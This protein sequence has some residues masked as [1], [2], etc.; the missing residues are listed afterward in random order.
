MYRNG[1]P[2]ITELFI[3]CYVLAI[4]HLGTRLAFRSF[5]FFQVEGDSFIFEVRVS[6]E[7]K[8]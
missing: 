4:D 8:R 3:G 7:A 1:D 5:N 2:D 6:P